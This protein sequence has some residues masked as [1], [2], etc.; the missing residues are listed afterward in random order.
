[1]KTSYRVLAGGM[2]VWLLAVAA[3]VHASRVDAAKNIVPS[4]EV[5]ATLLSD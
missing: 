1:M 4:T 3:V 5:S 2:A